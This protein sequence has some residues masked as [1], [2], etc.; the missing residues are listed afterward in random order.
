MNGT[1]KL[2]GVEIKLYHVSQSMCIARPSQCILS[3]C[4]VF[5][6]L[7]GKV[8]CLEMIDPYI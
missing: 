7:L 3:S 8:S 2:D 1:G 5:E 4:F 6:D